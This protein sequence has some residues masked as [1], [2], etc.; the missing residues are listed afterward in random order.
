MAR[1]EAKKERK[2][3]LMNAYLATDSSRF[4]RKALFLAQAFQANRSPLPERGNAW[5]SRSIVFV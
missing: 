2:K 5:M 4:V 1:K 3:P